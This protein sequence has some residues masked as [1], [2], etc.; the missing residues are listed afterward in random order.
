MWEENH[1]TAVRAVESPINTIY[2]GTSVRRADQT[3]SCCFL[4]AN[5][6]LGILADRLRLGSYRC[7][8]LELLLLFIVIANCRECLHTAVLIAFCAE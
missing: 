7:L 5:P 8:H 3:D 6:H 1:I 2:S 4:D